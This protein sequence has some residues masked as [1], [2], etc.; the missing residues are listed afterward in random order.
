MKQ[1]LF[2]TE[3]SMKSDTTD[4]DSKYKYFE[5]LVRHIYKQ[6]ETSSGNINER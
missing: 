2:W 4:S 3:Q 5:W 6:Q 1:Y